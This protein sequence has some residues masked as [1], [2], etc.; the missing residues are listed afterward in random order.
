M[1][2]PLPA[3]TSGA[4]LSR[5]LAG[6]R[7]ALARADLSDGARRA[8]ASRV[9]GFLSW[10]AETATLDGD[11]LAEAHARDFA[12]R[13]YRAHL[14]TVRKA[15]P[16]T[17]NAMLTALDHF[18]THHLGLGRPLARREQQPATAP[19][20]LDEGEQRRFLRAVQRHPSAR[21]RAVVLVLLYTGLRADELA[22]LDITDVPISTRRGKVIVRAG[23]GRDGGTYREVQLHRTAREALRVWLD[24]RPDWPAAGES[25]AL[26][27]NHRGGRLSVRSVN[28]VV[29]AIALAAGLVHDAGPHAGKARVHPHT[30]RH[31]FGTQLLRGGVDVVTVADLMGHAK[32]DSTRVYTRSSAADRAHAL[33]SVLLTDE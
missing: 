3:T 7:T 12:V 6:Y 2:E 15:K 20:A 17:I 10:L 25:A 22:Q 14:K 1:A 13:D 4:R 26:W 24:E 9:A 18:Y 16:T 29:R 27:L 19:Q 30:L 11:P 21:D 31:T 33:D 23:K 8:Y 28:T 5:V 32:L